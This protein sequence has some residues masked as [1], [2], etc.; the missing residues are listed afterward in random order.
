MIFSKSNI[1]TITEEEL[2]RFTEGET[3]WKYFWLQKD[4]WTFSLQCHCAHVYTRAPVRM[5]TC[6]GKVLKEA[7]THAHGAIYSQSEAPE[8][9]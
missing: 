5:C 9:V 3:N 8:Q 6:D 1:S 2:C 7:C 4:K